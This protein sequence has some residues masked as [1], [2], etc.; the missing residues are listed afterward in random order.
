[1]SIEIPSIDSLAAVDLY[2]AVQIKTAMST[3]STLAVAEMEDCAP[4]SINSMLFAISQSLCSCPTLQNLEPIMFN[5]TPAA[6]MPPFFKVAIMERISYFD[7]LPEDHQYRAFR[8]W[9]I[10]H[11]KPSGE[12]ALKIVESQAA[13]HMVQIYREDLDDLGR[14]ETWETV[15]RELQK[16][17]QGQYERLSAPS[18]TVLTCLQLSC[19][20]QFLAENLHAVFPKQKQ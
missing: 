5:N 6:C 13:S 1:M 8:D 19:V 11:E 18:S 2:A 4:G 20:E 10:R 16:R 9:I 7:S 12:V 14:M 15:E 17:L 3:W